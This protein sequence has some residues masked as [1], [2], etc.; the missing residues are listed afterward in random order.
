MGEYANF[1]ECVAKNQDKADP[2]AYCGE[3]KA[4][5]EDT[6]KSDCPC[7]MR[8]IKSDDGRFLIY[9][10]ASVEIIDKERDK[11][12]AT[13]LSASINQLLK[14][15]RFSLQHQDVLVGEILSEYKAAD[16]AYKTEVVKDRL[17]VVG[18]VW[19]DTDAGLQ[20]RQLIEKG[21]LR[22]FSISGQ[23]KKDG[24]TKVCDDNGCYR[25]VQKIDLHAVT[26]CERGMNPAAKFEVIHKT[27]NNSNDVIYFTIATHNPELIKDSTHA[28]PKEAEVHTGMTE[29]QPP[30][31]EKVQKEGGAPAGAPPAAGEQHGGNGNGNMEAK[32][33]T[34][35]KMMQQLISA[36]GGGGQ[37]MAM[38]KT[39]KPPATQ[40]MSEDAFMKEIEALKKQIVEQ[41][42]LIAKL[43]AGKPVQTPRPETLGKT[44]LQRGDSL[45]ELMNSPEKLAKVSP[46]K[47]EEMFP[48]DGDSSW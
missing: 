42:E 26:I 9:G 27:D 47:I 18:D 40:T 46:E 13:A 30:A 39:E 38:E 21:V 10:P 16:R 22:S 6:A 32:M 44:E 24:A 23:I 36:L 20:T 14:R 35:M 8:I 7:K 37:V 4:R 15:A 5:T 33:D 34:M 17:M 45:A 25:D 3:I 48:R 29:T 43:M 1:E 28:S 31:G 11:I 41:G 12:R 19:D 2:E